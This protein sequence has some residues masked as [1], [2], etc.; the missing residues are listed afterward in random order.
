MSALEKGE[1]EAKTRFFFQ[2]YDLDADGFVS[3]LDLSTM[4]HSSSMLDDDE[5]TAE[6]VSTFVNRVFKEFGA[7]VS[8]KISFEDVMRYMEKHPQ[9][10]VWDVFGRS[11]LQ[12]F[13]ARPN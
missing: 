11:M 7:E 13:S 8:G 5:T 10:D 9:A 2:I 12:D 1:P 6:V 4:F 3:R